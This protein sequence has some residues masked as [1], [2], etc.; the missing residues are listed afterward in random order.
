MASSVA[1]WSA[2][3]DSYFKPEDFRR[4]AEVVTNEPLNLRPFTFIMSPEDYRWHKQAMEIL[5]V[6][7]IEEVWSALS[8]EDRFYGWLLSVGWRPEPSADS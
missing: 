7:S 4:A 5:G 3:G 8:A 2:L 1:D 6:S